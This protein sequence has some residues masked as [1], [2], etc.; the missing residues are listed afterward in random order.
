MSLSVGSTILIRKKIDWLDHL[1][2]LLTDK[3]ADGKILMVNVTSAKSYS[4]RTTVLN[5]GDHPFITRESVVYYQDAQVTSIEHIEAAISASLATQQGD[6]SKELIE[7]LRSGLL[8]SPQTKN[9]FKQ[10]LK[11]QI[12]PK[13]STP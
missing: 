10:Y 3:D 11:T 13:N 12:P 9:K 7:K 5:E 4:D 2:I 6:A 1:W 8:K